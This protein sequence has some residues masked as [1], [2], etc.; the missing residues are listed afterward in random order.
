MG[1]SDEDYGG[2]E[3]RQERNAELRTRL[4]E[5]DKKVSKHPEL[6]EDDMNQLYK[7]TRGYY[8]RVP[9]GRSFEMLQAVREEHADK[10]SPAL[11]ALIDSVLGGRG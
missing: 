1:K 11:V 6:T 2:P 7:A 5:A 3:R 8:E 10:F 9:V 4:T